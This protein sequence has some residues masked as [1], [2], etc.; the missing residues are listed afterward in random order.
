VADPANLSEKLSNWP[1]K[2]FSDVMAD[3]DNWRTPILRYLHD[4]NTKLINVRRIA[5]FVLHHEL[6]QKITVDLSLRCF[7]FDQAKMVIGKV[8]EL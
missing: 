6:C 4:P 5:V 2:T 3:L 1:N 8:Y 7:G